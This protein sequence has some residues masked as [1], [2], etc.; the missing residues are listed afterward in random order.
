MKRPRRWGTRGWLWMLALVSLP[1]GLRAQW[2][3]LDV[4]SPPSMDSADTQNGQRIFTRWCWYCHG[5]EGDGTGPV[6]AYLRPRPRDFTTGLYK[7]RTTASGELPLDEDLYRTIT[8]GMPGT[9]MPSWESVLTPRERW[10]VIAYLKTFAADLFEDE[11]FDPYARIVERT[12]PPPG[13]RATL[14][15]AGRQAYRDARC[16][17]CH[18]EEGWGNGS[19]AGE[20]DDDL[21]M[22]TLPNNLH[23]SVAFKGGRTAAEIWLRF[24]TGL[25]GTPMPSYAEALTP[26]ERWQIAYYVESLQEEPA[27]AASTEAVIAAGYVEGALPSTVDDPA[28]TR[29]KAIRI[30]LT[31]QATYAPRWQVPGVRDLQISALFNDGEIAM[32]LTWSDRFKDTVDLDPA[33]ALAEGWTASDTYVKLYPELRR[34]RGVFPDEVEV[35]FPMTYVGRAALPRFVYG[36]PGDPVEVWNWRADRH[37]GR[38]DAI[39]EMTASGVEAPPGTLPPERQYASGTAIWSDGQWRLLLRRPL[40]TREEAGFRLQE[41]HLIPVAFHVREGSN[42]ETGLRMALSSWYYL[43]LSKPPP[44]LAYAKVIL[45]VLLAVAAELV[46]ARL[47]GTRASNGRLQRYGLAPGPAE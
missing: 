14:V 4:P 46:L 17:E 5:S 30:P 20:L 43:S 13:S 8:R 27:E 19:R 2:L 10:Q 9:A 6:A 39:V 41:G 26:G 28:W 45:S 24:S 22:P 15:A 33:A 34:V 23:S 38:G 1:G 25:D 29:A 18:G 40:S 37:L 31:G 21:G 11:E 47:I 36:S 32:L 3:E 42:G 12:A 7:L 44:L 35:L 16:W